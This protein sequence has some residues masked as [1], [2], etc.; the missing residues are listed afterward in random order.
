MDVGAATHTKCCPNSATILVPIWLYCLNCT[1]FGQLILRKIIKTVDTRCHILRLKCTSFD[2]GWGSVPDPAGGSGAE[3]QPKSNL[4]HFSLK[5]W[6][7]VATILI[8]FL[9]INWPNLVQFKH[10]EKMKS[11]FIGLL[12]GFG[13][14]YRLHIEGNLIKWKWKCPRTVLSYPRSEGP[15]SGPTRTP[16]ASART[17]LTSVS[18]TALKLV[19]NTLHYW[20]YMDVAIETVHM[21]WDVMSKI[22]LFSHTSIK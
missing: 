15:D 16:L 21:C 7:L 11:C 8:I 9:R 1:K 17:T 4:V 10:S 2:F 19:M 5:I 12:C 18:F 3:P 13:G 6:H 20:Q 22:I 14:Q